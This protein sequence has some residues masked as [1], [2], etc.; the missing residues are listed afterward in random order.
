MEG[1]D[2]VMLSEE[3]AKGKYPVES[4]AMMEK[5][6]VETEKHISSDRVFNHLKKINQYAW[7]NLSSIQF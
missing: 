1:A 5:I 2:A 4:V 7:I 3:S 6:L